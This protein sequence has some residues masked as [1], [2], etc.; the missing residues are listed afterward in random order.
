MS[1][2]GSP[3]PSPPRVDSS[4][5]PIDPPKPLSRIS[6]YDENALKIRLKYAH[7]TLNNPQRKLCPLGMHAMKL[8]KEACAH[9]LDLE[10]GETF[11]SEEELHQAKVEWISAIRTYEQTAQ[12][13]AFLEIT[14][15]SDAEEMKEQLL[16]LRRTSLYARYGDYFA[17][18]CTRLKREA[19]VHKLFKWQ[20]LQKKYWTEIYKEL[21]T[22]E[23][24]YKEPLYGEGHH[25]ECPTHM[26]VASACRRVGFGITDM[27]PIIKHYAIRNE[28][29][30]AN[31][32]T[33]VK[34]SNFA[35]LA[36]VLHDDYCDV[37]RLYPPESKSSSK[38]MLTLLQTMIDN[39]FE[40]DEDDFE[41]YTGWVPSKELRAL[42]NELKTADTELVNKRVKEETT[43]MVQKGLRDR[44]KEKEVLDNID[45]LTL[46]PGKK[47]KHV[48]SSQLEEEKT[49][50]KKMEVA[51]DKIR[52]LSLNF[53]K[54][55]DSYI[56]TYGEL[57]PPPA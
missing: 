22:E 42:K 25:T 10:D 52:G 38:L 55:S 23:P 4:T 18:V 57:G 1:S 21:N 47:M 12:Y 28:L 8:Y 5:E 29:L 53:R 35:G 2:P 7:L 54:M 17:D 48:T 9:L 34:E 43:K 19:E 14:G 39:W 16:A 15:T 11:E 6:E 24:A 33:L 41:T 37:P 36:K 45:E 51:W 49:T 31:L 56:V 20:S 40:Y 44:A 46:L 3:G 26:D 13:S 32:L 50:A 30:H 27:L